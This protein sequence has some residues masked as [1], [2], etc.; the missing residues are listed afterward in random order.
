[1]HSTEHSK[2]ERLALLAGRQLCNRRHVK[3]ELYSQCHTLAIAHSPYG[4]TRVARVIHT[5]MLLHFFPTSCSSHPE[6]YPTQHQY[7]TQRRKG[8]S[9]R[10]HLY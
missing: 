3:Q 7:P 1:M 5:Y 4:C 8:A 10:Q 2:T 9:G 6:T